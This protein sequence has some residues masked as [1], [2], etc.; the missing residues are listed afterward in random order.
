MAV[1]EKEHL[2]AIQT[3]DFSPGIR[4]QTFQ[5]DAK[6]EG[7]GVGAYRIALD[8]SNAFKGEG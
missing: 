4:H 2:S 6:W 3:L 1:N 8:S 7:W 5:I